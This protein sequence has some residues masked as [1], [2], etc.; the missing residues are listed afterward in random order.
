MIGPGRRA[1]I[2]QQPVERGLELRPARVGPEADQA[3]VTD[4][5]DPA[6]PLWDQA[7]IEQEGQALVL[8]R[9]MGLEPEGVARGFSVGAAD[10]RAPPAR[11]VHDHRRGEPSRGG[12]DR[13]VLDAGHRGA[14]EARPALRQQPLAEGPVVERAERDR[15]EIVANRPGGRADLEPFVHLQDAGGHAEGL[16]HPERG[17]ARGGLHAAD[18]VAVQEQNFSLELSGN[19]EAAEAGPDHDGIVISGGHSR[20]QHTL[21]PRRKRRSRLRAGRVRRRR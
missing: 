21:K 3:A 20:S 2:L 19:G 11:A 14:Q 18:L 16:R 1:V 6:Q 7:A 4:R 5:K 13:P 15:G 17:T 10:Q 9:G 12:D 8:E